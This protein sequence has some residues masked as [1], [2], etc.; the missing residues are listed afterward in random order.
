MREK[1]GQ[2][3]AG[4][5]RIWAPSGRAWTGPGGKTSGSGS[6]RSRTPSDLPPAQG[7]G[8]RWKGPREQG[9][10]TLVRESRAESGKDKEGQAGAGPGA[11]AGLGRR[12]R[13]DTFPEWGRSQAHLP[14]VPCPP[15][16]S[17]CS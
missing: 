2:C 17:V 5:R 8:P 16:L 7:P 13:T 14:G 1:T 6:L 4:V 11:G 9:R 12:Q 3:G 10:C 15:G